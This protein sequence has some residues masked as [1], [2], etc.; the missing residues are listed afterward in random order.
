MGDALPAVDLGAGRS[1]TAITVEDNRACAILQDGAIKCWGANSIGS[2]G[3]G[4]T[5]GRGDEPGEMG[6]ALPLVDL[7]AAVTP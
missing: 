5:E 2:L 1:A 6:D 4:D 7:P 3:L